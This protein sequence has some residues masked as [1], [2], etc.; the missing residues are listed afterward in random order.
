MM[1]R[2]DDAGAPSTMERVATVASSGRPERIDV[3]EFRAVDPGGT[4]EARS[5]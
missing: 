3:R 5:T 4:F 2:I 1:Q